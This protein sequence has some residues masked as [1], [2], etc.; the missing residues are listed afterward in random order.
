MIKSTDKFYTAGDVVVDEIRLVSYSG[1]EVDLRKIVGD[2]SITE[3]M[4]SNS[5]SGSL[6]IADS[7]NLVKNLPIIGDED[8]Y[9]SFYTPGV[10]SKPRKVRFKIYKV[11][12]YIRGQ[13]AANVLIRVEF[14]CPA[15]VLSNRTRLRKVFRNL[16]VN[17]MVKTIYSEMRDKE[18]QRNLD[19]P[20]LLTDETFG[21]TTVLIP[22]WSPFYTINWLA[23]RGV[24]ESNTQI[25]DYVFYQ[26]LDKYNFV[27][28]S[29]LK[30]LSPICTYKN[31]PGGF[32]S[33][34]GDRMLESELR[35]I[36]DYSVRDLGDKV[37]ETTMGVYA[38]NM[39]V[40][41]VNTKSY[42]MYNYT[43]KDAFD[44]AP[45][46][47]KGR[48][49]PY[50]SPIQKSFDAHVK[51]YDKSYFQ[52]SNHEDASGIDR[53]LNR[54]SQMHQMNSM[55]MVLNVYGDTTIRVGNVIRLEFF[56]QE[57]S[58]YRDDF[59]DEYLTANYMITAIVH[60]V[61]D[62]VHSMKMTVAR[63]SYGSELPDI[64]EKVIR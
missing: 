44:N 56:T 57:Y 53:F 14:M 39:L 38:S 5:L 46:L 55:T 4:F 3:D 7:M 20:E 15:L 63:D 28:I 37:D 62:G 17:E 33:A 34:S 26:D 30:K 21:S 16:P 51:Y 18:K 6:V 11:S 29:K 49:L 58:K 42:F 61:T 52:F 22:N 43:Y 2:F 64:K 47:N 10:D 12:S 25:A 59:L 45:S 41:E 50:Y 23:N 31:A 27:P 9:I 48:M 40:H 19:L 8:L 13:G 35:N 1:L 24:S 36:I 54:Q 60:N 32:R